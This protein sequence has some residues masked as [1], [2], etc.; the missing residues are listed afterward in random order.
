VTRNPPVRR[1]VTVIRSKVVT[2]G[3]AVHGHGHVL[4]RRALAVVD[5][6]YRGTWPRLK[7]CVH[8]GWVVYDISTNRSARRCSTTA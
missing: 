8:C 2:A 4:G 5:A 7:A 6:Q 1:R 3:A